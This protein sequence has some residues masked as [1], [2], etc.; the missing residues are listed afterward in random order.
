MDVGW[1]LNLAVAFFAGLALL[2]WQSSPV[3]DARSKSPSEAKVRLARE[4]QPADS[5]PEEVGPHFMEF[6]LPF[7]SGPID[8]TD[9]VFNPKSFD[10][11]T[12]NASG[13]DP[14][15]HL[16]RKR[17]SERCDEEMIRR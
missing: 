9:I 17:L 13:F 5:R 6:S 12:P 14:E 10:S 11:T 4:S 2:A 3:L 16:M 15:P 1:R 7:A 8:A